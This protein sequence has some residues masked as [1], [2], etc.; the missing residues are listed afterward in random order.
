MRNGKV[1]NF[2][3]LVLALA[4]SPLRSASAQATPQPIA[5]GQTVT[6][7]LAPDR[8]E[9][10]Y[11]FTAQAGD[12]ITITMDTDGNSAL[13]P[14]VI[15][16]DQSQQS[17]LAV[18]NDSGGNR[19]AR[20]RFVIPSAG[21]YVI[22]ATAVQGGGDINGSYKLALAL[23]NAT[24]TPSDAAS[25]PV[26]APFKPGQD[27]R[28]DLNDT[29]RFHI[30]SLKARKGDPISASLQIDAGADAVQAGLFLFSPDFQEITRTELGGTLNAKAASDGTYFL[31]VARAGS[32][33]GT[34][35]L[36]Q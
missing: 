29:V 21:T 6:G 5:Y 10:L 2:V 11:V 18:D 1:L 20:L 27:V 13:D 25:A 3:V 36:K 22:R 7:D 12:S 26:I 14:L 33:S 16:V 30:Y 28:G 24:P 8:T 32:G 35:T 17:V 19:N 31:M 23:S 4:T 15:L 34:F 9:A